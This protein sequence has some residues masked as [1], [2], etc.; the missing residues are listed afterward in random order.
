MS[1]SVYMALDYRQVPTSHDAS[2]VELWRYHGLSIDL[3][4]LWKLMAKFYTNVSC[5]SVLW[6]IIS[7]LHQGKKELWGE[8]MGIV[9]AYRRW[10][11]VVWMWGLQKKGVVGKNWVDFWYKNNSSNNKGIHCMQYTHTH[12]HERIILPS[13]SIIPTYVVLYSPKTCDPLSRLLSVNLRVSVGSRAKS[14]SYMRKSTHDSLS[15]GVN[16]TVW[17]ID[18]CC[19]SGMCVCWGGEFIRLAMNALK[20]TKTTSIFIIPA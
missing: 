12:T 1:H 8:G 6:N 20:W 18:P 11:R 9:T 15:W 4:W 13:S 5:S 17:S 3:E 7:S 19:R 2:H 16:V 10:S 14:S